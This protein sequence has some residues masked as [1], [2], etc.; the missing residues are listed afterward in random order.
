MDIKKLRKEAVR[1]TTRIGDIVHL[2]DDELRK[3]VG[4]GGLEGGADVDP[5]T[6]AIHFYYPADSL[7]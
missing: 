4:G 2:S 3:V 5:E 1:K 6:C 7:S